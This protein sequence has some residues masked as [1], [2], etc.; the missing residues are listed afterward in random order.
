ME[1]RYNIE[2]VHRTKLIQ[3]GKKGLLI[4][5]VLMAVFFILLLP[6]ID[7]TPDSAPLWLNLSFMASILLTV[8]GIYLMMRRKY[9]SAELIVNSEELTIISKG[10]QIKIPF[11]DIISFKGTDSFVK[12]VS[13]II[14]INGQP[15]LEIRSE[16]DLYEGLVAVFPEKETK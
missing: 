13:F 16:E 1:L 15:D 9:E 2:I 6:Y 3:Y 10:N 11:K 12:K 8:I 4:G 7:K 5:I 14:S